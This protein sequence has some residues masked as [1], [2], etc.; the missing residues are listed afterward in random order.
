MEFPI[1]LCTFSIYVYL[2]IYCFYMLYVKRHTFSLECLL[3][4]I[5]KPLSEICNKTYTVID[6]RLNQF[7]TECKNSSFNDIL[8]KL[9]FQLR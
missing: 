1:K 8:V 5:L 4:S 9:P 2:F 7:A 6:F 3:V